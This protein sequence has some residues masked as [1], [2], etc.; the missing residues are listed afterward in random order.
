MAD[1]ACGLGERFVWLHKIGICQVQTDGVILPFDEHGAFVTRGEIFN[2]LDKWVKVSINW[3]RRH[4]TRRQSR[5]GEVLLRYPARRLRHGWDGWSISMGSFEREN[6]GDA[7]AIW[8]SNDWL[9]EPL[10]EREMS[11]LE[12]S[13]LRSTRIGSWVSEVSTAR[14]R[15]S[16]TA[17]LNYYL[18]KKL[19]FDTITEA[20]VQCVCGLRGIYQTG[21]ASVPPWCWVQVFELDGCVSLYLVCF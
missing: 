19:E 14:Y 5:N 15:T 16:G 7:M 18:D 6:L 2:E 10:F 9:S 17:G 12:R 4:V 21:V 3:G 11:A 1:Q 8:N 20:P 13:R